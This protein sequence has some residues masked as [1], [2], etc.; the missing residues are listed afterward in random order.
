MAPPHKSYLKRRR[1]AVGASSLHNS[2]CPKYNVEPPFS[3]PA[4]W[5]SFGCKALK[6]ATLRA[7][8]T[9]RLARQMGHRVSITVA[10]KVFRMEV[11]LDAAWKGGQSQP[12]RW[13]NEAL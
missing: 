12:H 9:H 6:H 10:K 11:P 3:A 2:S 13:L 8:F 7:I 4:G 5:P 1:G